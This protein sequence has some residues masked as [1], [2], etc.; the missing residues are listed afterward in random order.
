M[1]PKRGEPIFYMFGCDMAFRKEIFATHSFDERL[2]RFSNYV[3]GDDQIFSRVLLKQGHV[4]G[5]ASKG[6]VIHRAAT[7][8][9]F[10][11]GFATG[12]VEGYNA[13]LIW[14]QTAYPWSKWT[15]FPFL[16]ARFGVFCAVLG[17]CLVKPMNENRWG[18]LRG[19]VAGVSM[20]FRD[21][22]FGQ[23]KP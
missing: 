11:P 15:V 14:I 6:Y 4:F 10:E 9:R 13:G 19:Y 23:A 7:G 12:R 8:G 2:Q 3:I 20:F 16:W 1:R 17:A 22:F 21:E 5:V 18:R